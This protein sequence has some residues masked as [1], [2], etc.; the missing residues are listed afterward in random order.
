MV[1]FSDEFLAYLELKQDML[2]HKIPEKDI[3]FYIEHS[4]KIG[5]ERASKIG[6]RNIEQLYA[7]SNIRIREETHDGVFFKVQIRAQFES[8]RKGNHLV[9]LYDQSIIQLAEANRLDLKE[10]KRI[11]LAHEFF[12]YL[13]SKED[14][15]VYDQFSP[16]E[17]AKFLMFSQKVHI[18]RTSEIA[19]NAFAK[20]LLNL[21]YLPNFYD[22]QYLL[23]SKQM[24][25]REIEEE[26]ESFNEL[27]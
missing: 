2:F 19:A 3:L 20:Y 6:I 11:I 4:L 24:S 16:I 9:Y 25:I 7:E 10:M 17:S 8:D 18:R 22:Y 13:E 5:S 27:K 1:Y 21:K 14:T 26:Y 15:H 23:D 12:H